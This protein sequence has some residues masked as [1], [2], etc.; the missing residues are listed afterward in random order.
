M[1]FHVNKNWE[2]ITS[3][4][5]FKEITWVFFVQENELGWKHRGKENNV[6]QRVNMWVNPNECWLCKTIIIMSF[7][8]KHENN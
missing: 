4:S 5:T 8:V 1:H 3:R 7:E 6:E 2:F